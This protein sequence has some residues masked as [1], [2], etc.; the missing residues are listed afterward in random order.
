M[1]PLAAVNTGNIGM[2]SAIP[3]VDFL[4]DD[5]YH[6]KGVLLNDQLTV[7]DYYATQEFADTC[8]L[9]RDWFNKG[10]VM[11][12][13]NFLRGGFFVPNLIGGIILGYIWKF[14]EKNPECSM[15]FNAILTQD[16]QGNRAKIDRQQKIYHNHLSGYDMI[17]DRYLNPIINLSC[18]M[19]RT[20]IMAEQFL[21]KL[22]MDGFFFDQETEDVAG[23][24]V[25]RLM[26]QPIIQVDT[27]FFLLKGGTIELHLIR[28]IL[29][30]GVVILCRAKQVIS[31]LQAVFALKLVR[32]IF[33][34]FL[35]QLCVARF[36]AGQHLKDYLQSIPLI[37]CC[38]LQIVGLTVFFHGNGEL[39]HFHRAFSFHDCRTGGSDRVRN[40]SVWV[41]QPLP[42][43]CATPAGM[44][45]SVLH[46]AINRVMTGRFDRF[47]LV[48]QLRRI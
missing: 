42:A 48:K 35:Q 21:Q 9:A 36:I 1:T 23:Y 25:G 39:H 17:A 5:M 40:V 33:L 30:A 6:P 8:A 16:E 4:T 37:F 13:Q 31:C 22:I 27:F 20:R 24:F 28:L 41:L 10:L 43:A 15:V 38:L 2:S 19:F 44:P 14:M 47:V 26:M 32:H 29:H 18:C 7:V 45:A 12:A 34:H 3:D 46:S 11:R